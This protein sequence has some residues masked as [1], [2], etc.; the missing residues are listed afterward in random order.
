M[1]T[2]RC[3]V[4]DNCC[5][6]IINDDDRR[7]PRGCVT[8]QECN[9]TWREVENLDAA[10]SKAAEVNAYREN[11]K[12]RHELQK[13]HQER[14]YYKDRFARLK[15]WISNLLELGTSGLEAVWKETEEE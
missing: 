4:C 8:G 1:K 5:T 10:R 3:N 12:L 13:Q 2:F 9:A 7:P 11:E 14:E 15:I 6:I